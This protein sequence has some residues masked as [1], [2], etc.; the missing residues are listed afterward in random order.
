MVLGRIGYDTPRKLR[1]LTGHVEG[2]LV[3][4]GCGT[5]LVGMAYQAAGTRL[6]GVDISE[7]ASTKPETKEST[8]N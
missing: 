5:G 6:V 7:K 3:D 4:L 1:D 2:T 8:E